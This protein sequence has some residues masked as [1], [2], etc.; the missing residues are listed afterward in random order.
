MIKEIC[1]VLLQLFLCLFLRAGSEFGD[2]K[3]L[4]TGEEY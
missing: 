1:S 4:L 3:Q 2:F